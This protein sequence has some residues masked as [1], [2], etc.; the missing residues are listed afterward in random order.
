M[1]EPFVWII[2]QKLQDY[3]DNDKILRI[4]D[5]IKKATKSYRSEN[6]LMDSYLSSH[7]EFNYSEYQDMSVPISTITTNMLAVVY[8]H[9][10]KKR[11]DKSELLHYMTMN[12]VIVIKEGR[13]E[14][15]IGIKNIII[16]N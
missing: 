5:I 8:N 11:D 15:I 3:Y 14:K 10:S 12:L 2:V 1:R 13:T 7:Y 4:P 16:L 9:Q 6:D